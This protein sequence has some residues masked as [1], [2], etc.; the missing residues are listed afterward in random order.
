MSKNITKKVISS[1]ESYL[2]E[3]WSLRR[4]ESHWAGGEH[5]VTVKKGN[6]PSCYGESQ[7]VWSKNGKWSG[8]NSHAHLT[9]TRAA[10]IT[11]PN[12]TAK[13]GAIILDCEQIAPREYKV[14]FVKQGR[15]FDINPSNGWMIR[16]YLSTKANIN[17]ARKEVEV[18]RKKAISSALKAR[19]ENIDLRKVF[20]SMQDSLNAGNCRAMSEQVEAQVKNI[21]GN[22]GGIRADML[23][24]IRDDFYSRRAIASAKTRMEEK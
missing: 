22:V 14:I 7:R 20:V 17:A 3:N 15:G 5:Y 16:G 6:K 2:T 4:S 24:K 9:A 1:A 10:F 21:Y 8:N 18:E 23:L 13:D 12:L 19:H 11:F